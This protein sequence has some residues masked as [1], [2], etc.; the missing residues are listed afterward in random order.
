MPKSRS[1]ER[2][3]VDPA[4]RSRSCAAYFMENWASALPTINQGILPTFL[5]ADRAT[6]MVATRDI[7]IAAA[8]LLVD[9]SS[10]KRIVQLAGP[11]EYSPRDVAA[12]LGRVV[13]KEIAA[14][15]YPDDGMADALLGAGMPPEW[16][17]LFQELARGINAGRVAWEAG[18]PI[19]RGETD[20]EV[21]LSSMVEK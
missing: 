2:C 13:G 21:V 12:A 7:G 9:G 6:P 16:A 18:H 11:Q 1:R 14:Q 10:G 20:V 15:Q 17:R 3:P 19:W 4:A 5:L 8:R